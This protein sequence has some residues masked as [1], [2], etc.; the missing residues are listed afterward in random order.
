MAFD[1]KSIIKSVAPML[2]AAIGGP[3][4]P[5]AGALISKAMGGSPDKTSP[6]DLAKLIQNISP[7]QL[8]ALKQAEQEFQLQMKQLDINSVK[9]LEI[10]AA[11]DRD[12]ARKREM[13]V[14]DWTPKALA[15]SIT[16]GFFGILIYMMKFPIPAESRDVLNIMLGALGTAWISVISYYFGSSAGSAA[17]N[18]L[19]AKK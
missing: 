17:K 4:A 6:D 19:L 10:I 5:I 13:T 8:L 9:D 1:W 12:S 3:F 15:V 14:K 11:G 16:L 2:G 7:E 18:E